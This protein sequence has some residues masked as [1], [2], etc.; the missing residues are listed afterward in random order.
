MLHTGDA[1]DELLLV[2]TLNSFA[3]DFAARTAIGG[4][5]L[6][7]FIIKQLP[8]PEPAAFRA[9]L[10]AGATYADFILP[11]ALE[12]SYTSWDLQPLAAG[13]GYGERAP[14]RWEPAR[15]LLVRCE[16]EAAF[17][18]L[19]GLDQDEVGY[20]MDSFPGVMREDI[21]EHGEYRT[22]RVVLEIYDAIAAAR[23]AG[24]PY[25][26]RLA[27]PPASPAVAHSDAGHSVA[28]HSAATASQ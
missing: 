9:E 3:L 2:A 6:S 26:T 25:N 10:H 12:L 23:A 18:H 22:R 13:L 14:F 15:R 8:V 11:R 4:T 16:L 21:Q 1:N 20:I 24:R 7:Y 19:Y 5:D 27:P 17:F 28:G